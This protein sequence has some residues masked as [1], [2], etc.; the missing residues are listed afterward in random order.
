MKTKVGYSHTGATAA[1][2]ERAGR[3]VAALLEGVWRANAG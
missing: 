1:E 2:G 3:A